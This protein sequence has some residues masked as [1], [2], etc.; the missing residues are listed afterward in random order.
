MIQT[1]NASALLHSDRE[2]AETFTLTRANGECQ[3]PVILEFAAT[4]EP[5]FRLISIEIKPANS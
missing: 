1:Y 2:A 3:R 4:F 5:D